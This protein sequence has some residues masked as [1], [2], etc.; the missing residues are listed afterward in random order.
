MQLHLEQEINAP[1][2]RVW[3]VLGQQ[4]AE[5]ERWSSTVETSRSLDASEVPAGVVADPAA[6]VLGRETVSALVT[7]KEILVRYSDADAELTFAVAGLP[8]IIKH[9]RNTQGVR[10]LGG[11]RSVVTFDVDLEAWGPF[12]VLMPVMRRRMSKTFSKV[13]GDLRGYVEGSGAA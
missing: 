12:K 6:P 10:A 7:A 4:F 13:L 8:K 1:A 3:A 9:A 11:G 2:E 5:I